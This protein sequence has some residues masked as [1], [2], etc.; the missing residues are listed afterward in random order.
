MTEKNQLC[1]RH[2]K[3]TKEGLIKTKVPN[4]GGMGAVC[5]PEN[6]SDSL[7]KRIQRTIV[8]PVL[9][10]IKLLGTDFRGILY[11]GLMLTPEG[12]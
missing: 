8:N 10:E 7:S 9:K 11:V 12:A 5:I 6:Y 4:T 1:F 3:T 2:A